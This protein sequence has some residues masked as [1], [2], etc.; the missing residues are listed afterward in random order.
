MVVKK[1]TKLIEFEKALSAVLK[2]VPAVG[3]ESLKL[4]SAVGRVLMENI[5]ADRP[6]PPFNRS[7]MDGY[8][9]RFSDFQ[10]GQTLFTVVGTLEAGREWK[11][12]F[13]KGEALKIMTGAPV[14]LGADMVIKVENSRIVNG[15]VGLS[16]VGSK[17]RLNTGAPV[18]LG[19]DM[20]IKVEN[21]KRG[22]DKVELA[23]T[24][25]AKWL[26]VHRQGSDIKKD[27]TVLR[28]GKLL[29]PADIPTASSVG[30]A[31]LKVSKQIKVSVITTGSEIVSVEKKPKSYEIRDSN[32][33]FLRATLQSMPS[34]SASYAGPLKDDPALFKR[35]LIKEISKSDLVIV[36]GGVSMGDSDYTYRV[37]EELKVK[38]I[39][40]KCA[41]RPGKP[42]WF[43][44]QGR[45]AIFGLPGNP[46][47]VMATFHE[48]VLPAL[49]KM[50]CASEVMPNS[51]RSP[52]ISALSKKHGLREFRPALLSNEGVVSVGGYKGSGDFINASLGNGFV[53]L[54]EEKRD[55]PVGESVE[56]HP[57]TF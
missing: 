46:V 49:K 5:K 40:H 56:F 25:P 7:A 19:A 42:I 16:S 51:L 24:K 29:R 17:K 45:C 12:D 8:A 37:L 3:T 31:T 52:L 10:K 36:T 2:N 15:V 30:A 39:F 4:S 1:E 38:K 26:N 21:S 41:I 54:P 13:K 43:G 53:V 28:K 35:N 14:P 34:I 47:S 32:L 11:G 20:V 48:F 44:L 57:W 23:E 18:P 27:K 6:I 55:F 50:S 9:V 22:D 33:A